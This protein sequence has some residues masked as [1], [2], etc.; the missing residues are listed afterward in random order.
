M[1]RTGDGRSVSIRDL[2]D[3]AD[4]HHSTIG[5]LLTGVQESVPGEV[6][7]AV[8]DRIGV[9]LPVLWECIGR[10]TRSRRR[11]AVSA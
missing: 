6:A 2:A 7:Q 5:L 4:V 11:Q 10:T 1:R 8:A 3:A 9:D